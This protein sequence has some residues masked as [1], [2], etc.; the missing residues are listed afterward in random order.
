MALLV[1]I[2]LK[3]VAGN[4]VYVRVS[5]WPSRTVFVAPSSFMESSSEATSAA[6]SWSPPHLRFGYMPS[7]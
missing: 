3:W 7:T 6:F 5:V 2:L 4:L 1:R